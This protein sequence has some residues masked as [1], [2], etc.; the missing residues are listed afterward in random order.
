MSNENESKQNEGENK[1]ENNELLRR[2][3][4][5]N[6][7]KNIVLMKKGDYTVHILVEEVKSLP[8]L[9]ENHLPHPIVK[10]TVFNQSKRTEKTKMPCDSYTYDEHFYFDKAD[11][12]VEQLDSS[13]I[14]IEVYDS[15][16]SKKRKDYYGICEFDLEYIYS[17]KDHSL[18]N[19]WLALS[20]PESKDM[21]KIR[22][23]LKLSISVLHDNDPR[24]ELKS[25]P[26]STSCFIPSQ[27]KIEYK[28]LSIYLIRGEEFPDRDSMTAKKTNRKCNPYI[29]FKY[30]GLNVKSKVTKNINDVAVWNQIINIPIQV[31]TV[32]QKIVM[33]IR[34]DDTIGYDNIGSY[35]INLN[36]VLG[37][38][39]KYAN[40][41]YIDIYGSSK[42]KKD[43]INDLMNENAEIGSAWN[44]R[45]L[46]KIEYKTTDTPIM[47]KLDLK[48]ENELKI[49]SEAVNR[50]VLW[51]IHAKLY[52]AYYL[53]K[54]YK[55]YSIKIMMQESNMLFEQKETINQ[56][57]KWENV[58]TMQFLSGSNDKEQ[59]P[60]MF[61]YLLN[62]DGDPVC[63]QRIK[64]TQFHLNDQIMIIKLFPEPC[65]DKV[66]STI[67]SGLL[68]AKIVLYNTSTEKSKVDL[69]KFKDGNSGDEANQEDD[70]ENVN[71]GGLQVKLGELYR[72]V[73]VVYMCRYLMSSDGKGTNDPYVRIT[74]VDDKRETSIKHETINGIWNEALIFDGVQ[75]DLKKK[76]T[77]PILLAEVLDYDTIGKGDLL[78]SSYVWLS[79]S[80]YKLNSTE[81]VKPKWHQLYLPKSNAPLGEILLSFYIFDKDHYK[82]SNAINPKPKTIPYTFEINIL[83]LRDIKPLAMLPIKKA[84]IKFDMNS[85]NVSGEKE[86]TLPAKTTQPKDKGSNPTINSA[87]KFDLNLPES[88]IFMPQLQCQVFDYIFSGMINPTLGL[89]L[90]N[91][92]DLIAETNKQ[93]N[94]DLKAIRVKLSYYMATGLVTNAIGSIGGL[95]KIAPQENNDN[96]I[97]TSSN[98]NSN[99]I[100]DDSTNKVISTEE[101][102]K[103]KD[104]TETTVKTKV[105]DAQFIEKNK[106]VAEYFVVLPQY[107]N[108]F[109]PGSKKHK[110]N[111]TPYI[112]EDLSLAPSSEYYYPIGYVPKPNH[113]KEDLGYK[114]ETDVGKIYNIKKHYRRYYR[115][116]LEDS[117]DLKIKSPFYTAYL[118]RGK[119]KD[120][121]DETA[122]FTAL[123]EMN[124]KII[125]SYDPKDDN[126]SFE[127]K[128]QIKQQKLRSK[129]MFGGLLQNQL[130]NIALPKNL[131][132]RGF[133]KFKGVI[134]VCEKKKLDDFQRDIEKFKT[135]NEKIMA[136]LKNVEKYEKLTKS[137]LV[138]HEVIIRVYVLEIRDLPAKDLLSDSDPYIKIYFGEDK[139]F[140]EQ[141]NH[142]ND[143]KNVKWFKYY[144]ILSI[145]PGE[146]T[147][148]IEVWDYNPIF[149]DELIGST[150]IDLEDRYFNNDWQQLKFKPIETRPLIHPDI[151]GQQG[152]ILLWVEIF[153]KK[154]SINMTPW[155]ISPEPPS[156]VELRLVVW[157]TEEMR[158]MDV[159]DTSDIYVT[160]FIDKKL[161]QSTDVH[162]RCQT[163][164]ASFNW[165]I[166][167]QIDVPRVNN[168][169]TLHCYDKDIFSKDDF[170]SEAEIDLSDIIKIPEDLDVPIT[171]NKEYVDSVSPEEKTKYKGIEFLTEPEDAE[172]NK[173]WVQCYHQN[174][175]SGRIL[176]SFEILP[177]WKAE[178]SKV[179]LGRKDPN[180]NPYLP[181]PVG[182]F[183]WTLNPFKL[184]NQCVGPRFRKK[185]YCGILA[186][187]LVIYL[188]FLIP[189]IIYH[190]SGQIVNPFNW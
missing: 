131:M 160:A 63:F 143:E 14:I 85:L 54:E 57:I 176:C 69:S 68:K 154:D 124:N 185:L 47:N 153:D 117:N 155:Q 8:Q 127:E 39:N 157:E 55:K 56:Y 84:F 97:D 12:T 93:I 33:L 95:D 10:L 59:L 122:I 123:S 25:D 15:S 58:K 137:I 19:Y 77:W 81:L 165:R 118:R 142:H 67:H 16:Y 31:P 111:K 65:Y 5:I 102:E 82:M 3:S 43:N 109:I 40:Y 62:P 23:Y 113:E 66:K 128:E 133:G 162:Y 38:E 132:D 190:L 4:T 189:Y 18:N 170:I 163:G 99:K 106:N 48:D 64:S 96:V 158:M 159:E 166:V 140:D 183:Q 184:L 87:L 177:M 182:R 88:E 35:E 41:R 156:K 141:K 73:C 61:F 78:G 89:F 178:L 125:K 104:E 144:D 98:Q 90:L 51:T 169:L 11:L 174:A 164:N 7:G 136:E 44:G 92:K 116:G 107:K 45:I 94:E 49:S 72:V 179:G 83:G 26:E 86:D 168:K 129:K 75:L 161:K 13:K 146:S 71:F 167:M 135:K 120:S 32:S 173:F 130:G 186:C 101:L 150:S 180:V 112:R 9:N 188:I 70:L 46:L 139:K 34:D 115:T 76:S 145:F 134:R 37:P 21:T 91:I 119:D 152:N 187:C 6:E 172:N 148:R 151:A 74:C 36:D 108:Y 147:L 103:L 105:Y 22:G 29:E 175:E 2:D 42:N 24:V 114:I 1:G 53:P 27:I 50:S 138:N 126:K 149:K 52:C 110:G 20:N 60:D 79:D 30:F 121:K 171:F 181:P 17:M 28:Q 80:P 100:L